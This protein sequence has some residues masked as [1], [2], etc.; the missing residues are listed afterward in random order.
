V[1]KNKTTTTIIKPYEKDKTL[2]VKTT[3]I[4]EE[5]IEETDDSFSLGTKGLGTY[6]LVRDISFM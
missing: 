5:N 2:T 4:F 3:V 6:S 1:T